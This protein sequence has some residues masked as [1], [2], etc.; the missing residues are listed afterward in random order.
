MSQACDTLGGTTTVACGAPGVRSGATRVVPMGTG[1][2]YH[3]RIFKKL[4]FFLLGKLSGK[5]PHYF[6]TLVTVCDSLSSNH[7]HVELY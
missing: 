5:S 6:V 3:F 1:L 7:S 4:G 2:P